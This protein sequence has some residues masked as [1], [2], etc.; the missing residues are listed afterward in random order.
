MHVGQGFL[1]NQGYLGVPWWPGSWGLCCHCCG[2][3]SIPECP[4]AVGSAK[5]KKKGQ[6]VFKTPQMEWW[7]QLYSCVF[8]PPHS[9]GRDWEVMLDRIAQ[10]DHVG[11]CKTGDNWNSFFWFMFLAEK[12]H[13]RSYFVWLAVTHL[14]GEIVHCISL[15]LFV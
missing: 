14:A 11:K 7:L 3:A 2:L 10:L 4:H 15:T 1:Y 6:L 8:P 13:F 5:K 12:L 9:L